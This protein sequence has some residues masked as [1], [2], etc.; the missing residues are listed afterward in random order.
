MARILVIEDDDDFRK[1]LMLMLQQAGYVTLEASNGEEGLRVYNSEQIDLVVTDIF[2]P[3]KEGM[4]TVL[5]LMEKNPAVK[6]IA[7]SGGGSSDKLEY[8]ESV[9]DFGVQKTFA[10]PFVT[11][12]FLAGISELLES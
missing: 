4:Q 11:R 10:K 9:K 6:I 2:M 3:E 8:L 7:I 12:E 5:E 1:M